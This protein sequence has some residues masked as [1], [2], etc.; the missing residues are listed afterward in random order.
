MP[1]ALILHNIIMKAC[2]FHNKD[3]HTACRT[4]GLA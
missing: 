2:G 4:I 1:P 3:G